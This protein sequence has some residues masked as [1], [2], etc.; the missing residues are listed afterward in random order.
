MSS[1]LPPDI[2]SPSPE[3]RPKQRLC[4]KCRQPFASEGF[5]ERICPRCKGSKLWQDSVPGPSSFGRAQK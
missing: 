1:V 5:G 3:D 4:L 2:K